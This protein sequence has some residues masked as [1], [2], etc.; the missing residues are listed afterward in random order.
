[1]DKTFAEVWSEAQRER[2]EYF[3]DIFSGLI[4]LLRIS[5]KEATQ[6]ATEACHAEHG[7]LAKAA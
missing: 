1:M 6:K 2:S 7:T 3:V 4:S 5:Q